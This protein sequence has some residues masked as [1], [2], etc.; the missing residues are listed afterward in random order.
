MISQLAR[1]SYH[2]SE[3][4]L[5]A[6]SRYAI[7]L[8]TTPFAHTTIQVQAQKVYRFQARRIGHGLHLRDTNTLLDYCITEGRCSVAA[9]MAGGL[10]HWES[11]KLIKAGSSRRFCASTRSRYCS[12]R[13]RTRCIS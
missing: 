13:W 11:L 6:R 5:S 12:K 10:T 2:L 1:S 9:R 8:F 4:A 3:E 7:K